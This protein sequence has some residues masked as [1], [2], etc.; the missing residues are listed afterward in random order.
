[1]ARY[2]A[3]K[4]HNVDAI[5]PVVFEELAS[6]KEINFIQSRFE[7]FTT[8]QRYDLIVASLVSHHITY[9][10]EE[11]LGRLKS[12]LNDNGTIYV[13]LLGLDDDWA[14]SPIAKCISFDEANIIYERAGFNAVYKAAEWFEGRVYSGESKFWNLFHFVLKLPY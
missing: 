12:L 3:N 7:D 5:D 4:G 14:A 1:M 9:S 13:T 8:T 6:D 2:F 11:F 10:L